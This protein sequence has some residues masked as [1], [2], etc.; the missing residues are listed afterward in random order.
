M[1]GLFVNSLMK[2]G[3][4]QKIYDL[5]REEF[6]RQDQSR[7]RERN[8]NLAS[9]FYSKN[10]ELSKRYAEIAYQLI[11]I[12][13]NQIELLEKAGHNEKDPEKQ[14]ILRL[15]IIASISD[16]DIVEIK[17]EFNESYM[18]IK[19]MVD[20]EIPHH[21]SLLNISFKDY[22]QS[23]EASIETVFNPC[24][25]SVVIAADTLKSIAKSLEVIPKI[26][27]LPQGTILER[28]ESLKSFR[29]SLVNC[30]DDAK[31]NSERIRGNL[32]AKLKQDY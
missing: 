18:V 30:I 9:S 32:E 28:I 8:Y 10:E 13:N 20:F 29:D 7:L 6:K 12:I 15:S 24:L 1:I 17:N 16:L 26:E 3:E 14:E 4:I 27:R 31:L 2:K 22:I 23:I 21:L 25:K 11:F 19:R 5:K